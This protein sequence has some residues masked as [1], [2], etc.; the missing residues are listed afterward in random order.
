M[1]DLGNA[2]ANLHGDA[3]DC[4]LRTVCALCA[5]GGA[6]RLVSTRERARTTTDQAHNPQRFRSAIHKVS[7]QPQAIARGVEAHP[8]E[9]I[10]ELCV[11]PLHITYSVGSHDLSAP[12]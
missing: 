7:Q 4:T 2:L 8:L 11:A 6:V 3:V 10:A 12:C 1:A 5:L 9:Q